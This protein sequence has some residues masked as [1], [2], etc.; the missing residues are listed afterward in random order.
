MVVGAG[1]L[2][3]SQVRDFDHS[4]ANDFQVV[5]GPPLMNTIIVMNAAKAPTDDIQL[6]K[7]IMHA[8]DKASI[9]DSELAGS[10]IVADSLFPKD[11]PYCNLDLTPRW[12]Y[13]IEKATLMNC[14]ASSDYEQLK[15]EK[16]ALEKELDEL[17]AVCEGGSKTGKRSTRKRKATTRKRTTRKRRR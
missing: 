15:S 4:H 5:N 12:D 6:R 1:V 7:V 2:T 10:A 13:D 17:R 16:E 9:V 8:V 3:P 11:A 14:P